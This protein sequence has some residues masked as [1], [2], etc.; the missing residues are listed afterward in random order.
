L[1]TQASLA[2]GSLRVSVGATAAA[3][4]LVAS[5]EGAMILARSFG[6]VARFETATRA[7][8]AELQA[9]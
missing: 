1:A 8:L 5:L 2:E 6:E 9:A 4:H 7:M 3:A